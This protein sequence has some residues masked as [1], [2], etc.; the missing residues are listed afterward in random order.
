MF[1]RPITLL[2]LA[3]V[4]SCGS[5]RRVG[6]AEP[7]APVEQL[8]QLTEPRNAFREMG[9]LAD[10]GPV[11][12]IGSVNIFAGPAPDSL[13]VMVGL[14]LRNHGLTFRRDG[15]TFLA[16]Y[17]VEVQLRPAVGQAVRAVRDERVRV[18]TF[19][20]TQRADESVIFQ[21]AVTATPGSYTLEVVVRDRNSP[22]TGRVETSVTVPALGTS[23]VSLPVA[24]YE[25]R[26]R[27]TLRAAPALVLNPRAAIEFGGDSL[28]FYL[29]TYGLAP[30]VRLPVAVMDAVGR[31]AWEDTVVVDSAAP[32]RGF[33]IVVPSSRLS[34]G[35]FALRIGSPE[36]ALATV[37]F[38]VMFSDQFAVANI[39]DI[40]SLLRY[41][42]E[43][44]SLRV[45]LQ[46][47][48]EEQS[49]AWRRFYRATDPNPVTT[50]NEAIEE[51]LSR[52]RV[53][54]EMFRDEGVPGWL[55]ERGEV[56]VTIG[57]PSE[58]IDR[59]TAD[60]QGR[61][62]YIIWNY[63]DLRLTL[64]FID[65]SGFGRYRLDPASRAEFLRTVNRLRDR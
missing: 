46:G 19:N 20:E 7:D 55:T 5:W 15:D 33:L 30:G 14:S 39:A 1:I 26:P 38:V 21:Q 16:E 54:N 35:R 50:E 43:R 8:P 18:G 63:Y 17:R 11:G 9:L 45:L 6:Q 65:D 64:N 49:A 47:P 42:P 24:V 3:L 23:S 56:F 41:F 37:P 60:L 31:T 27:T 53:A 62:R 58:I 48:P 10:N 29:E 34:V 51:Y 59:R 28:R 52:L 22:N 57:E 44:D 61:A 2:S 12:F 40:V 25:A 13:L 36:R 32:V 4:A